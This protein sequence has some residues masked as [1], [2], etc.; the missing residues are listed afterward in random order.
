[1]MSLS[2]GWRWTIFRR[3]DGKGRLNWDGEIGEM[4]LWAAEGL[5]AICPDRGADA[6]CA[7]FPGPASEAAHVD[8]DGVLDHPHGLM[9]RHRALHGADHP[10]DRPQATFATAVTLEVEVI[11]FAGGEVPLGWVGLGGTMFF[12]RG[13][14]GDTGW[15]VCTTTVCHCVL[16]SSFEG[17]CVTLLVR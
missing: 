16:G 10:L 17:S 5:I 14:G 3:L 1:V 9:R 11:S 13:L 7:I 4:W 8:Q 12:F 6:L 2:I 15:V